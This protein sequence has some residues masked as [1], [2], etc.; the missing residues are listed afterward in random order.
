MEV[1]LSPA[2]GFDYSN[3][4]ATV[5]GSGMNPISFVSCLDL[6]EMCTLSAEHPAAQRKI[7]DFGG[8]AALS[9]LEVIAKFEQIAGK[10]FTHPACAAGSSPGTIR[11]RQ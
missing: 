3:A 10:P 7:F 5:Y 6:A 8:P 4:A 1:W 9:P 11:L 2:L